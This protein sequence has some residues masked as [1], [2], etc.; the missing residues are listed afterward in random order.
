MY[1]RGRPNKLAKEELPSTKFVHST[2]LQRLAGN[3]KNS[4]RKSTEKDEMSGGFLEEYYAPRE[5]RRE[6]K[7]KVTLKDIKKQR[8]SAQEEGHYLPKDEMQRESSSLR[9]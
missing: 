6:K 4:N 8:R 2:E 5:E 3:T 9:N 7:M 1:V